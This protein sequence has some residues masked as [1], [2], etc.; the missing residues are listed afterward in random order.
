[1]KKNQWLIWV[2]VGLAAWYWWMQK[3]KSAASSA[4]ASA[5][6]AAPASN[7][8]KSASQ[9]AR[10]IVAD[11]VDKTTFLPDLSTDRNLYKQDQTE[12]K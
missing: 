4:S 7:Y 12:C 11:V 10:E 3:K 8:I 9:E 1:M 6:S 5:P 2:G